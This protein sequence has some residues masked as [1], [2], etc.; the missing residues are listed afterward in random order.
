MKP[1]TYPVEINGE[2][3]ADGLVMIPPGRVRAL[4]DVGWEQA[5]QGSAETAVDLTEEVEMDDE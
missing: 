4:E 1:P 3:F 5:E 2:I